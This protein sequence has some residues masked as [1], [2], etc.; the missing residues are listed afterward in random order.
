MARQQTANELQ[1]DNEDR[2]TLLDLVAAV[3]DS[4]DDNAEVMATL[5]HMAETG[6][7]ML[8]VRSFDLLP[9]AA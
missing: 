5:R 8:E 3:Q 2:L 6:H 1:M 4:A 7:V 9:W